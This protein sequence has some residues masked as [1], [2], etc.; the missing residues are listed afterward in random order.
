M[1]LLGCEVI[2]RNSRR[3]GAEIDLLCKHRQ[4]RDYFFFEVK[5]NPKAENRVFSPVSRAQLQR[6]KKAARQLQQSA[7]RLL[8]IRVCLLLVDLKCGRIEL[9]TDVITAR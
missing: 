9:L 4:S 7:D 2:S 6:L 5:K 8:T 3:H 1:R